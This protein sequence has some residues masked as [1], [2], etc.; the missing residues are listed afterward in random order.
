MGRPT[1]YE[2][3]KYFEEA[4]I[5]DKRVRGVMGLYFI[6]KE[7]PAIKLYIGKYN[8]DTFM[9]WGC[10]LKM[11][12]FSS[13]SNWLRHQVLS[14]SKKLRETE[15]PVFMEAEKIYEEFKHHQDKKN[16]EKL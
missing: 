12:G 7:H 14:E 2:Y 6:G 16:R 9:I 8:I 13:F 5:P 3:E 15:D 10:Y 4:N 1:K 11:K